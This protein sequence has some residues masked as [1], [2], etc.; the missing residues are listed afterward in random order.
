MQRLRAAC[1]LPQ[2]ELAQQLDVRGR[3]EAVGDPGEVVG[4]EGRE[5]APVVGQRFVDLA[6]SLAGRHRLHLALRLD[7]L[8]EGDDMTVAAMRT[9]IEQIRWWYD[10][11]AGAGGLRADRELDDHTVLGRPF[12]IRSAAGDASD[13]GERPYVDEDV[14][15]VAEDDRAIAVQ[16]VRRR[17]LD[18]SSDGTLA[19]PN[20]YVP[21]N[22]SASTR[23]SSAAGRPTTL[24]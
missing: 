10:R 9:G 8:P 3:L 23:T 22:R 2:S 6:K 19:H 24:R 14:P 4:V 20:P 5:L 18:R 21:G 13:E 1:R 17:H 15:R 12:R 11:R 7:V 16:P